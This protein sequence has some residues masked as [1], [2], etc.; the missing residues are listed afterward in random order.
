VGPRR[1]GK[2]LGQPRPD[3]CGTNQG[4]H[5]P[6]GEGE[7]SDG[8]NFHSTS[9]AASALTRGSRSTRRSGGADRP[10]PQTRGAVRRV[11][12]RLRRDLVSR[13]FRQP[14][15]DS[16]TRSAV[17]ARVCTHGASASTGFAIRAPG[18]IGRSAPSGLGP[19][20]PAE[21]WVLEQ[22]SRRWATFRPHAAPRRG[23]TVGLDPVRGS[24]S[25][26]RRQTW[27]ISSAREHSHLASTTTETRRLHLI[28]RNPAFG[29]PAHR[30]STW[31]HGRAA[32]PAPA[33]WRIGWRRW[34]TRTSVALGRSPDRSTAASWRTAPAVVGPTSSAQGPAARKVDDQRR[35]SRAH[36]RRSIG[37]STRAS[38]RTGHGG[39]WASRS[40]TPSSRRGARRRRAAA[41]WTIAD[42]RWRCDPATRGGTTAPD[43]DRRRGRSQRQDRPPRLGGRPGRTA[44]SQKRAR[45]RT[46]PDFAA[47]RRRLAFRRGRKPTHALRH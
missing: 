47:S 19:L 45:R 11:G 16:S 12:S 17:D 28:G 43:H 25:A 37:Q 26:F 14:N 6:A 46:A 13:E 9:C 18:R 23:S 40:R 5:G 36:A 10:K 34:P 15:N 39:R 29:S 33:G 42:A 41:G 30:S 38:W 2:R 35:G 27:P 31:F 8:S 3:H 24:A 44:R 21:R 4:A 22:P 7:G 1:Q 32:A 20:V